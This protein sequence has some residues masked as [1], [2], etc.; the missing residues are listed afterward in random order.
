M[1]LPET[2]GAAILATAGLFHKRRAKINL[3]DVTLKKDRENHKPF[4]GEHGTPPAEISPYVEVKYNPYIKTNFGIDT[5]VHIAS[6]EHRSSD[7]FIMNEGEQKTINLPLFEGPV[8][9]GMDK[10]FLKFVLLE[11]DYYPRYNIKEWSFDIHQE[12]ISYSNYIELTNN[13][14]TIENEYIKAQIGVEIIDIY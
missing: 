12:L 11:V 8:F 9:D 1:T 4:D 13:S 10:L 7:L 3:L 6:V 14:F 5:T 2:D